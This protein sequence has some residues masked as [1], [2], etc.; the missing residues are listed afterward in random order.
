MLYRIMGINERKLREKESR[1]KQIRDCAAALFYK[2]GYIATTIEDIAAS[3]EISKGTIYLYF[4]SKDDLYYSL[5]EPSLD[6]LSIKLITIAGMK[7]VD[8]EI[9]IKNV[10]DATYDFYNKDPDAYH[11]V[12]RYEAS[13]FSNLL[14]KDKLDHLKDLMRSNLNQLRIVISDGVVQGRFCKFDPRMT[15]IIIWNTFMGIIQFQENRFEEGKSD[16]R[17]STIDG[18]V[19]I[20]LRGIRKR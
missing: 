11:L 2:K 7:E 5:V 19:D 18:A 12:S 10:I 8:P 17:R 20:I 4:K 13:I 6:K 15:S 3:A 14:S 1:I 16:Y 9:R